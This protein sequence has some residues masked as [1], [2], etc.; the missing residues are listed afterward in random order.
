MKITKL[1]SVTLTL[2]QGKPYTIPDRFSMRGIYTPNLVILAP[3][4]SYCGNKSWTDRR[5]AGQSDRQTDGRHYDDNTR[6]PK[7]WPRGRSR[8]Q[9]GAIAWSFTNSKFPKLCEL[10]VL[11][12]GEV[13][14]INIFHFTFPVFDQSGPTSCIWCALKLIFNEVAAEL[15]CGSIELEKSEKSEF[16]TISYLALYLICLTSNVGTQ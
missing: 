8:I 12:W 16:S 10:L 2:G 5:T 9:I 15:A 4:T 6:W 7:V 1:T 13:Q 14:K 11:W 3:S